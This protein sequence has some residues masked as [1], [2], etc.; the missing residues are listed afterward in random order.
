VWSARLRGGRRRRG[1]R[2]K[3][4]RQWP[5]GFR[6]PRGPLAA[7]TAIKMAGGTAFVYGTLMAEE[8]VGALLRR[9]PPSQPAVLSGYSR[10]R[11]RGQ[12]RAERCSCCVESTA[13]RWHAPSGAPASGAAAIVGAGLRRTAATAQL[14]VALPTQA[15]PPL[16]LRL[17][18][19]QV[20][21]AIIPAPPESRVHGKARRRLPTAAPAARSRSLVASAAQRS[22]PPR[23]R[24]S[25]ACLTPTR[26]ETGP[27]GTEPRRAA[28]A[29]RCAAD[30]PSAA[31]AV[32]NR[33]PSA[34]RSLAPLPPPPPPKAPRSTFYCLTLIQ[35]PHAHARAR[36]VRRAPA[37]RSV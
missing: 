37:G 8:V 31:S 6:P 33:R 29:G 4:N 5:H 36:V 10:H 15:P 12:V 16:T 20:F 11:V 17:N 32:L 30:T 21:P 35:T 27:H 25:A 24:S 28:R 9:V 1:E 14:R 13:M 7:G 19:C 26:I 23:R 3:Q 22:R 34:A 18:R 2:S